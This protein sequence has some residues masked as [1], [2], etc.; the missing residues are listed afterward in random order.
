MLEV[1]ISPGTKSMV[2]VGLPDAI[3]GTGVISHT[4]A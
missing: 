4:H 1:H 3:E 2:I